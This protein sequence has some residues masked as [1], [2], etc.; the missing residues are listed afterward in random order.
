MPVEGIAEY[1]RNNNGIAE[2]SRNN[3]IIT[4]IFCYSFHR[5]LTISRLINHLQ[6][7]HNFWVEGN[8]RYGIVFVLERRRRNQLYATVC[9]SDI[10][11]ETALVLLL[12]PFR[13]LSVQE[14]RYQ[15][16]QKSRF[17]QNRC[18]THMK[19]T[20]DLATGAVVAVRTTTTIYTSDTY[21][22]NMTRA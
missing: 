3:I 22:C 1:S 9:P 19:A 13:T 18:I 17:M 6:L 11:Y 8:T 14:Y 21:E 12:Q 7:M 15:T 10:W 5:H 20:K 16:T 4:A 2:Y